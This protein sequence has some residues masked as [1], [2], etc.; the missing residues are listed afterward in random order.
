MI[1]EKIDLSLKEAMLSK[2][3]N[4]LLFYIESKTTKSIAILKSELISGIRNIK[5]K[6]LEASKVKGEELDEASEI[7]VLEK[8]IRDRE[9]SIE[10]Y[11]QG[12]RPD[13]AKKESD[14]ICI[15]KYYLPEKPEQFTEEEITNMVNNL[16]ELNKYN[17]IKEMGKLM[18]DFDSLYPGQADKKLLSQIIKSKL[19]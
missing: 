6:L 19:S 4:H 10:L 3:E 15:I 12:N 8:M 7:K 11:T 2:T 14:E 17:S 16:I 18:K 9:K 5:S 13:L 1:K